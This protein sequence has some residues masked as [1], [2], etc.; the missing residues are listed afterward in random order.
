M[1]RIRLPEKRLNLGSRF[2]PQLNVVE[3]ISTR[4]GEA[5]RGPL[6]RMQ[7]AEAR[8]RLVQDGELVWV[9][10]P[11]R[12]ELAVLVIDDAIPRGS[13]S[14]RDIAG[15][16]VSEAVTVSKP[17]TDSPLAGRHFG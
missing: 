6:V 4:K 11:R 16:A 17:D 2:Q 9:A 10:G 15:V 12:Q 5:E 14:L 3:Y 8:I 13:V 1:K 7:S